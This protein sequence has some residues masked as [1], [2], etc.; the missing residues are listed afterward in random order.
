MTVNAFQKLSMHVQVQLSQWLSDLFSDSYD[1]ISHDSQIH[2]LLSELNIEYQSYTTVPWLDYRN[3][4]LKTWTVFVLQHKDWIAVKLPN[5]FHQ[6]NPS[7]LT[8][9]QSQKFCEIVAT[10]L[11]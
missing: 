7:P 4:Q 5:P 1:V 3:P 8:V 6:V 10:K 9:P 11:L 2:R